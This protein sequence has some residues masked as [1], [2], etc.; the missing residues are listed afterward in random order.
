MGDH[1]AAE[2][3]LNGLFTLLDMKRPE[4]WQ[5]RFYG[6]LQRII[7]AYVQ[8]KHE[9]EIWT[10]TFP[11]RIGSYIAAAKSLDGEN[12]Q[13]YTR[14]EIELGIHDQIPHYTRPPSLLFSTA[15]M[16]ATRLSPFYFGASPSVE[17]CKADIEGLVLINALRR[18]SSLPVIDP[19]LT[20]ASSSRSS[21]M[22]PDYASRSPSPPNAAERPE[23]Y[24]LQPDVTA[25]LIADTDAYISSLL[26][27]PHPIYRDIRPTTSFHPSS[28]PQ[29]SLSRSVS[30]AMTTIS[31]Y[32]LAFRSQ[33]VTEDEPPAPVPPPSANT[34]RTD[35]YA[36]LPAELFP[37]SSRAWATAA[38]LFLHV[39]LAPVLREYPFDTPSRKRKREDIT[40]DPHLLRLLLDTLRADL[41]HTEEAMR[42]GSYS[43]ELWLW[44]VIIGAYTIE[45][46][47]VGAPGGRF[48][49][50]KSKSKG[51]A[52]DHG[53]VDGNFCGWVVEG[54]P[55][56]RMRSASV[57]MGAGGEIF[58]GG[59]GEEMDVEAQSSR[60]EGREV[61]LSES[62]GCTA[63]AMSTWFDV[64]LRSWSRA[65]QITD[66]VAARQML[67][68]IVWPPQGAVLFEG[69]AIV[70]GI[71]RRAVGDGADISWDMGRELPFMLAVDPRL[72]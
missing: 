25:A 16:I 67:A 14:G 40:L 44:K 32:N 63:A 42:L 8:P 62:E 59:T 46:A 47:G 34:Q 23:N 53:A 43:S 10:L 3:H 11:P 58:V 21:S 68:K 29:S 1:V 28:S 12:A 48:R 61:M 22:Q 15:P 41:Q 30:P 38:Y 27:K 55:Q 64:R 57:E 72:M 17:A 9:A 33:S 65:A 66:W 36:T 6:L 2:A 5:H 71:W 56:R 51:K 69:E 18:L 50:S 13:Q 37:S 20:S 31:T 39:L 24:R 7:L 26:F 19:P 52:K 54:E 49:K 45:V 4:E 35:P 60:Q 70:E